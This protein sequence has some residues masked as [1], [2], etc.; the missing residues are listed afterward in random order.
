MRLIA[1]PTCFDKLP[2][3]H[4]IIKDDGHKYYGSVYV[5]TR[6]QPRPP[7]PPSSFPIPPP[8]PFPLLYRRALRRT[9][10]VG[11]HSSRSSVAPSASYVTVCFRVA[12]WYAL[13]RPG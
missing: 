7:F 1:N 6:L 11:A 4:N 2:L 12:G 13:I 10:S 3:Q 8:P 5:G 9:I